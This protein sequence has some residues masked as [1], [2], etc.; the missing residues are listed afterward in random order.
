MDPVVACVA[1]HE[2]TRVDI[3]PAIIW[4]TRFVFNIGKGRLVTDARG[5][6]LVLAVLHSVI[7]GIMMYKDITSKSRGRCDFQSGRRLDSLS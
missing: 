6:G 7:L 4:E 1:S 5:I 3:T 2:M